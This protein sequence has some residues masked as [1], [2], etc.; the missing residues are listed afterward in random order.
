VAKITRHLVFGTRWS[1]RLD[2]MSHPIYYLSI[3]DRSRGRKGSGPD[4]FV[5][6]MLNGI[7]ARRPERQ[8]YAVGNKTKRQLRKE[9]AGG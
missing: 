6:I 1:Y 5:E 8:D 9:S 2:G 4:A 7:F 3:W